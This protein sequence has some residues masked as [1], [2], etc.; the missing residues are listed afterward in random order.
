MD[1]DPARGGEVARN[2]VTCSIEP[3]GLLPHRW[4]DRDSSPSMPCTIAARLNPPDHACAD[5]DPARGVLLS[6]RS[7]ADRPPP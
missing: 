7:L 5:L 4:R 6:S 3:S 1:A 2:D